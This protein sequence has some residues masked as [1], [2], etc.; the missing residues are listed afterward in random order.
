MISLQDMLYGTRVL[1]KPHVSGRTFAGSLGTVKS[2]GNF[3]IR[4]NHRDQLVQS[5]HQ[6]VGGS[7][8]WYVLRLLGG[9]D[10]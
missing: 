9:K 10:G 1:V 2:G 7:G 5:V 6:V 3:F 4:I 8:T